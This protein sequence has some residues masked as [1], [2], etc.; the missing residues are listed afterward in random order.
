MKVDSIPFKNVESENAGERKNQTP[1]TNLV[2]E[3]SP[4]RMQENKAKR[5]LACCSLYNKH[6]PSISWQYKQA[7]HIIMTLLLYWNPSDSAWNELDS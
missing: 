3:I 1:Q 4:L 6:I 5:L 7:N 2:T